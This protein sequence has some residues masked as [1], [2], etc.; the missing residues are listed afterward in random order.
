MKAGE[1]LPGEEG[2]RAGTREDSGA[3]LVGMGRCEI[4]DAVKVSKYFVFRRSWK[5]S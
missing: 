4:R 1:I 5:H 3:L 2:D